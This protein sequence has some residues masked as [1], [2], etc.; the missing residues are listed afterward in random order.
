MQKPSR[1]SVLL[2]LLSSTLALTAVAC[3]QENSSN[4]ASS[5]PAPDITPATATVSATPSSQ[6]IVK[7]PLPA[8]EALSSNSIDTYEL[9]LD[10]EA[11]A[12]S[13]SE[14][15]QSPEDWK[16]VAS[17]WQQAIKLLQAVPANSPHQ[18][19]A[20]TK[21][22]EYQKN[23][24]VAQQ[25][26]NPRPSEPAVVAINP[27]VPKPTS[28]FAKSTPQVVFAPIKYRMGGTP[29]IEVTFN[30]QQKFDM[31]LDT[32]ASGVVITPRMATA[33][34]V[35]PVGKVLAKT[36]SD[37]AAEF[38]VGFVNSVGIDSAVVRD[39]PVAIAPQLDVGLLGQDFFANYDVTIKRDVIEF[40]IR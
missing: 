12:L 10:K 38:A 32:G 40:H 24:A 19:I 16:L 39:V 34:G 5:N 20:K 3:S 17:R 2:L 35:V 14:S 33:L 11:S 31:I 21:L 37:K 15:A 18:A 27:S 23:L 22:A 9:A 29:V 4:S 13:I 30:N 26:A 7:N 25:K 8:R 1:S 28:Q 6:A 36:P